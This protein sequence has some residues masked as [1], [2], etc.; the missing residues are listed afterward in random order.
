[1]ATDYCKKAVV[2]FFNCESIEDIHTFPKIRIT[3][4]ITLCERAMIHHFNTDEV[5][6][7]LGRAVGEAAWLSKDEDEPQGGADGDTAD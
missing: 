4:E 3:A 6:Y 1:M 7:R 5:K 2:S